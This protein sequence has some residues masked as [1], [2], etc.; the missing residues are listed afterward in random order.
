MGTL[1]GRNKSNHKSASGLHRII[2]HERNGGSLEV[3]CG[4]AVP[5]SFVQLIVAISVFPNFAMSCAPAMYIAVG[6]ML[7]LLG[8]DCIAQLGWIA[9]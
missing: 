9:L 4:A 8:L 7:V 2:E 6:T 1:G 3:I 5:A